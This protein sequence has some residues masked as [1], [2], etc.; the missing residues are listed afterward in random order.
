[1]NE[2]INCT[3]KFQMQC[4]RRWEGLRETADPKVRLCESCLKEVHWCESEGEVQQRAARG[5][6]VAVGIVH[7]PAEGLLGEVV[8][9]E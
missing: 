1:M 6:C 8:P 7:H 4:P 9:G 3:W 2:I 5:E